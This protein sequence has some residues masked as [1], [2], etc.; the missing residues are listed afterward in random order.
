MIISVG[1]R[2]KSKRGINF[3]MWANKVLKDY[4]LKGYAINEQQLT[5]SKEYYSGFTKSIKFISELYK[6]KNLTSKEKDSLFNIINKYS[7]ALETLDK[8]D[9]RELIIDNITKDEGFRKL[10][11]KDI[12]SEIKNLPEYKNSSL[13]GRE[14]DK[15]FEGSIN[16][17]YQTA[18]GEEVYPSI[19]EKAANLLYF[20]VKNHSFIDG[21]KRIAA[22]IFI[23]FLHNNDILYKYD[24][25]KLIEDNTLVALVL[26]VA[27]SDPKEREVV[28]K[29]IINLINKDNWMKKLKIK[30][31]KINIVWYNFNV[32]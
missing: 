22:S 23:W 8:Y 24:G 28:V 11:Y 15:S 12:L 5:N 17:I 4:L 27:L 13:F 6:Q 26:M 19:E 21:N 29:I 20:V 31:Y 7:Y 14:K 9:H 1:Y 25:S 32:D 10:V 2:I 18:F 30:F 16:A 3:R